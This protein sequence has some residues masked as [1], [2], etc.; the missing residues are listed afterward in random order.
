MAIINYMYTNTGFVLVKNENDDSS[1]FG[2]RCLIS[3][4]FNVARYG[5]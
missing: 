1:I 3:M 2:R 4:A 5:E